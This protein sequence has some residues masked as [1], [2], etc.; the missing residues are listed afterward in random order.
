MNHLLRQKLTHRF[1]HRVSNIHDKV[2]R[3]NLI[4]RNFS[5]TKRKVLEKKSYV[6]QGIK[7]VAGIRWKSWSNSS[8][9]SAI[10]RLFTFAEFIWMSAE[11][12]FET[13]GKKGNLGCILFLF[14]GVLSVVFTFL[15]CYLCG[16]G[17]REKEAKPLSELYIPSKAVLLWRDFFL[18]VAFSKAPG[19]SLSNESYL[20][21]K[22]MNWLSLMT[23]RIFCVD[24]E[25]L[26]RPY[27]GGLV[28]VRGALATAL[29]VALNY[30]GLLH[31]NHRIHER[32]FERTETERKKHFTGN[33]KF[34]LVR[35]PPIKRLKRT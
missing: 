3:V 15:E 24:A 11:G 33:R 9:N 16:E 17:F 20:Y 23:P 4:S 12:N 10:L 7:G 29:L 32:D 13:V 6:S 21:I 18:L 22:I 14:P 28:F 26:S 5:S 8:G 31:Y 30:A 34:I 35:H 27:L 25:K 2:H 1:R 19:E